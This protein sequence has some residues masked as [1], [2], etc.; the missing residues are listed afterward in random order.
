MA[1]VGRFEAWWL[2]SWPHRLRVRQLV[3]RFLKA[4][5]EPF[6]GDVLE[7]GAGPGLTSRRI[8]ETYPQVKL[9]AVDVDRDTA[10][11]MARRA[12]PYG[13]RFQVVT[14][15]LLALPFDRGRFD[16]ALAIHTLHHVADLDRA[17]QELLRVL[18]PGGLL[19][20]ADM[21]QRYM[22]GPLATL[23]PAARPLTRLDV[24]AA[25]TRA[26]AEEEASDGT[27]YFWVWGTKP[28]Q[29]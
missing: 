25:L 8:L 23:F 13:H 7:V 22:V 16:I 1:N 17:I 19:G 6:R 20:I 18:R 27:I 5:P 3:P 28:Y 4:C 21:D 26:G 29:I 2:R 12:A 15:D 9:T 11:E 24:E 10:A 14:A